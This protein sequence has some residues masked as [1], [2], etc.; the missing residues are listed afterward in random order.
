[1]TEFLAL[2]DFAVST[3]T[4]ATVET[5]DVLKPSEQPEAEN[6]CLFVPTTSAPYWV[7]TAK[8]FVDMLLHMRVT[9]CAG[10][11]AWMAGMHQLLH[12]PPKGNHPF[13]DGDELGF[14]DFAGDLLRDHH[15]LQCVGGDLA[16]KTETSAL[17][18]GGTCRRCY[19]SREIRVRLAL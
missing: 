6:E 7:R 11:W 9:E 13:T 5:P 3:N 16:K 2:P 15:Y 14:S 17:P 4:G 19:Q 1:M 12:D 18:F 10:G 8:A